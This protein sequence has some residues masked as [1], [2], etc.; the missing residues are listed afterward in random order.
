MQTNITLDRTVVAVAVDE[1]VHVLIELTAPEAPLDANRV[2]IDV[3][4]ER[5]HTTRN[6]VYKTL[7]DARRRLRENLQA[8]GFLN[9][10]IAEE[11]N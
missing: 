4:A 11:V 9:P 1:T 8:Q 5:L 6:T 10:A 7:H 2:P 3:V